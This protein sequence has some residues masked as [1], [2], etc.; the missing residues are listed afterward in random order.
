MASFDWVL[1]D[2][3]NFGTNA[4]TMHS[5]FQVAQYGDSTH[6]PD[7]TNMRGNGSLPAN[8]RFVVNCIGVRMQPEIDLDDLL[9]MFNGSYLQM[10]TKDEIIFEAPLNRCSQDMGYGGVGFQGSADTQYAVGLIHDGFK[11]TM[12]IEIEGGNSF[13]VDIYQDQAMGTAN[14]LVKCML[15]GILTR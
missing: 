7:Y 9:A 8:E 10:R 6:T 5:L 4:D 14:K 12:P 2:T 15:T 3:A 1:Y 11:L 13:R